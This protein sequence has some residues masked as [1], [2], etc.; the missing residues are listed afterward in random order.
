MRAI[1]KIGDIVKLMCENSPQMIIVGQNKKRQFQ[2]CWFDSEKKER[3]AFYPQEALVPFPVEE[4][5]DEQL[6]Q[7]VSKFRPSQQQSAGRT[8]KKENP[9]TGA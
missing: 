5:T 6:H 1:L 7:Q 3:R 4:L 9:L 2:C 8:A